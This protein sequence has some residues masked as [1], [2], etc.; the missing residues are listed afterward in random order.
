MNTYNPD[1]L[2]VLF[3]YQ[4]EHGC[5]GPVFFAN[6]PIT[7]IQQINTHA[8]HPRVFDTQESTV[9]QKYPQ[10]KAPKEVTHIDPSQCTPDR[11]TSPRVT[12]VEETPEEITTNLNSI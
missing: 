6:V 2:C 5:R 9:S 3:L 10:M 8:K 11:M 12:I 7:N 4:L 1:G